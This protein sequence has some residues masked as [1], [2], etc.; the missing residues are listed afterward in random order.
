MENTLHSAGLR[1]PDQV[2]PTSAGADAVKVAVFDPQ[3]VHSAVAQQRGQHALLL[4]LHQ[5]GHE[6]LNLRHGHIAFVVPADE[7]L[8][9]GREGSVTSCAGL[10]P[11]CLPLSEL[12]FFH[13]H[14]LP[15]C[16][17]EGMVPLVA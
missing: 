4:L 12:S 8:R 5:Q 15:F 10:G 2:L 9:G 1:S 14:W 13:T 16:F 11:G 7:R 3:E 17:M 6:V